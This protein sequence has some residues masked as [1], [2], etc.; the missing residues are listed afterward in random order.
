VVEVGY[1]AY[2]QC[3]SEPQYINEGIY[4]VLVEIPEGDQEIVSEHITYFL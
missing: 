1:N 4:L 2:G 3:Q